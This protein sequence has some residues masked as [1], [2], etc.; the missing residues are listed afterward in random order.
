MSTDRNSL[1]FTESSI[2]TQT[3]LPF[4]YIVSEPESQPLLKC[5][6]HLQYNLILISLQSTP[7]LMLPTTGSLFLMRKLASHFTSNK[8]TSTLS[9]VN[10]SMTGL[11]KI[12]FH[13]PRWTELLRE[14]DIV[15]LST[16][17]PPPISLHL[18]LPLSRSASLVE[19]FW[20]IHCLSVFSRS[21]WGSINGPLFCR[22]WIS[23]L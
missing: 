9:A 6:F 21:S 12:R 7:P 16:H 23:Y 19:S 1:V 13:S 22:A 10:G 14:S 5:D 15:C 4:L 20:H 18:L 8:Q 3:T 2:P 17:N 11:S